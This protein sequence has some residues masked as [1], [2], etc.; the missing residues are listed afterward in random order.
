MSDAATTGKASD[1]VTVISDLSIRPF[2]VNVPQDA[3]D[4]LRRRVAAMRWPARETVDDRTQGVQLATMEAL[5]RHW[6]TDYDW[7][8]VE[9]Q[10]P[11]VAAVHHRDRRRGH[12][13][14]PRPLAARRRAC[15]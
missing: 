8:T 13:L 4:D 6:A 10:A 1:D 2:E 14:H 15:R 7:R 3:L 9:A 12:P 11:G 5:A